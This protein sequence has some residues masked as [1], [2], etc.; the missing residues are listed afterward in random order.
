MKRLIV[1]SWGSLIF[2]GICACLLFAIVWG[3]PDGN[4]HPNVG[5][6]VYRVL[7]DTQVYPGASGALISDRVFLTAG[8]VTKALESMISA[9]M[10]TLANIFICFDST[11]TLLPGANLRPIDS[12][13]THPHYSLPGKDNSWDIGLIFLKDAVTDITP[14]QLPPF[15][16]FLDEL[17]ASGELVSNPRKGTK[18]VCVGYGS[19]LEFPPPIIVWENKDR[20]MA[21]S[22][23][24]GFNKYWLFMSQ[25]LHT[26][27]GGTGYGDSGGPN[28]WKNDDG[29]E[30]IVAL[31]SQGDVRLVATNIA[32]RVDTEGSLAFIQG[33]L[34]S[35]SSLTK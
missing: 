5:A 30:T 34:S 6:I 1:W 12:I 2:L 19:F 33:A 24:L 4:R 11:D 26:G 13:I 27:N 10:T 8:H 22:G 16:N 31:T 15:P 32:Y 14:A 20:Y 3:E 23:F 7:G 18:F 21:E 25:N 28:F 17:K 29:T 35:V 9:G